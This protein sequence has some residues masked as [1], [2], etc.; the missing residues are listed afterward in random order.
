MKFSKPLE[1]TAQAR[2]QKGSVYFSEVSA[3]YFQK[4]KMSN[5]PFL[6]IEEEL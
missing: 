4:A 5:R 3:F 1:V 6:A 2:I